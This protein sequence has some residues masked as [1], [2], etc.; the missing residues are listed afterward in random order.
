VAGR[1]DL[2]RVDRNAAAHLV[3]R[4][5]DPAARL[6][7]YRTLELE[8]PRGSRLA[9]ELHMPDCAVQSPVESLI[10]RARTQAVQFLVT[11][12][13]TP[14]SGGVFG[15][16]HVSV[17][18]VPAG[19]VTFKLDVSDRAPVA[20]LA[21]VGEVARRYTA[22][23]VSYAAADR[24]EVL[25]RVQMLPAL[26]IKYFQDIFS[27]QP[28]DRWERRIECGLDECDLFLLFWSSA[29]RDSEW[30]RREVT[31]ALRRRDL[32]DADPEIRPVIREGPPVPEPWDELRHL[33]FNDHV[34]YVLRPGTGA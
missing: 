22:A 30:V 5:L 29:A 16:V 2:R 9:F 34:L 17:S 23:F 28:G 8:V 7:G 18:G 10:W 11:V 13:A 25:R 32:A 15:T 1:L 14:R 12:P 6:R 19:H 33:H 4:E 3:A 20:E 21:P 31:H 27:L 26:G 24:D